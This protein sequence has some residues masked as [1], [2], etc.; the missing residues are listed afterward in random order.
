MVEHG[1]LRRVAPRAAAQQSGA[2]SGFMHDDAYEFVV[3]GWDNMGG[4]VTSLGT[5]LT[6]GVALGWSDSFCY[7]TGATIYTPIAG[8]NEY[9]MT[10]FGMAP[11]PD[12]ADPAPEPTTIAL[13][14][15]GGLSMLFPRRK[16]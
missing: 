5:A 9:G 13:A 2:T 7:Q 8:F 6:D 14:G 4:T 10:P 16:A 1:A 12:S 15:L 11:V 3:V